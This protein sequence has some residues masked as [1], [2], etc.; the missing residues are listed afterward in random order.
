MKVKV[1]VGLLVLL[2]LGYTVFGERG[3][4]NLVRT[5]RQAEALLA[6]AARLKEENRRLREEIQ[7]LRSDRGY[8]ERLAREEL[9]MVKPGEL[10][11]QFAEAKDN[12]SPVP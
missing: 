3:L 4:V 2:I 11:F 12:P 1:V 6:E 10:V 8:I 5:R 7:R 9:G